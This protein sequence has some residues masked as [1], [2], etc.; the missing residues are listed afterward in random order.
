MSLTPSQLKS[1]ILL[2]DFN[3]ELLS[4]NLFASGLLNMLSSFQLTQGVT[5]P[6]RLSRRS[7]TPIDH[8]YLSDHSILS[9]FSIIS[10]ICNSDHNSIPI[11][12][13]YLKHWKKKIRGTIWNYS[14][15]DWDALVDK[16]LY[17]PARTDDIDSSWLSR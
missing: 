4:D 8:A 16:L 6:T 3:I 13:T 17:L 5:E 9:S 7:T 14:R 11:T 2:A 15:A 12:L 1:C 10:P